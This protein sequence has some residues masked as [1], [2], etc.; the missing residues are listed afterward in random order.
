LPEG[1]RNILVVKP[2]SLGDVVHS[3]PFLSAIRSGMPGSRIDWVIAKGLEGLLEGHPFINRL[4]VIDKESWRRP[5]NAF[6]TIREFAGLA[7]SLRK[8]RY[9]IAVDL[10]GLFRSG[11]ITLLSGAPVR[12][13]FSEAREGST[14]FYNRR[15]RGGRE[16]HAVDRYLRIAADL[17]CDTGEARFVFPGSEL[18][19]G[20]QLP[21][22]YA[23]LV[24]GARWETKRWP[25]DMFGRVAALLP[26]PS[27]VVGGPA[28]ARIADEAVSLSEGKAV[29]LAGRTDLKGLMEV[30]RR[31]AVVV[32][33]DSGPMH[34][35]TGFGVAVVALFGPTSPQR[36]GP[37]GSGHVVI[38]SK[39]PCA[40]CFKRSCDRGG[41]MR[42]ITP[43]VVVEAASR[44]LEA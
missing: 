11:V 20:L 35:A 9:D 33:N 27:V 13:G 30:M 39:L 5:R 28:D 15:V 42:D 25:A 26:L 18:P 3:L 16:A 1:I 44:V 4:I 23:V 2:S 8:E 38:R 37:Y 17:G 21:R 40:P 36:T 14:F 24:P 41:C 43:E 7:G 12:I 6:S 31:A 19:A 22:R 32:S 29:S 34:I 10:Q